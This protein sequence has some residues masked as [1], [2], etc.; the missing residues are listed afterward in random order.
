MKVRLNQAEDSFG[1]KLKVKVHRDNITVHFI[2]VLNN[3]ISPQCGRNYF[4]AFFCK[5]IIS[6]TS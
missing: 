4:S 2:L 6:L 5:Q 1:E 3:T